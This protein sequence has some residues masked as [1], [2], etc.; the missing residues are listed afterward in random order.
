MSDIPFADHTR[1]LIVALEGWNDAGDAASEC[2]RMVIDHF[3]LE[4]LLSIDPEEYFDFQ[5]TRPLVSLESD[6]SR[7]L[8]WPDVTLFGNPG[9]DKAA[10]LVLLGQEPSRLWRSFAQ[11]M[12]DHALAYD[13]EAIVFLGAMLADVPHSRPVRVTATSDDPVIRELLGAEKSTYEGPVGVLTV[14]SLAAAEVGIPSVHLWAQVPHYVH[15]APSPKATLAIVERLEE[16]VG[17]ALER[18]DLEVD[19]LR[20][21][22]GIDAL[23]EDDDDMS[24]YIDQLERARDAVD[25]PEASG[26][27]I[28]QE[29]EKYL[30]GR[31][32]RP[33]SSES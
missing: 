20:W 15:T 18:E 4:P 1:V 2:A 10:P 33:G 24:A 30:R 6:G 22:E 27:A 13:V 8:N 7:M 19:A 17:I 11:R 23:A 28:A 9:S 21:E 16:M 29:F 31:P 3:D 14:L 26:D 25:A 5:L 12:V 32:E